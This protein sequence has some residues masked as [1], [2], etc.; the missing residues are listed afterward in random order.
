MNLQE[1]SQYLQVELL[2]PG[3]E[4]PTSILIYGVAPIDQAQ[5][6]ELTFLANIKY[7]E[8][9][10]STQASAVI[11]RSPL[12]NCPLPQIIHKDPHFAFAKIS[13]LFYQ[14]DHGP[15]SVSDKAFIDPTAKIGKDVTV[16]PFAC[17]AAD[18][19]I[20]DRA[21]LYPGV[22]IGKQ[23]SV[24]EDTVIHANTVIGERCIIGSHNLIHAGCVIG[25]DGF[26]FAVGEGTI[27]KIPQMGIVRIE[28]HVELGGCCTIDRATMG[29]THI[30][31]GTKF[32]SKVHIGHNAKIGEH[33]MFSAMTAVGGSAYV[34]NGV[35]AGGQAA[36]AGHIKIGDGVKI[37]AKA[38]V[39]SSVD[40]QQT[41][42]GFPAVPAMQWRRGLIHTKKMGE[43]EKKIKELEAR[44][45]Q[46][47][48]QTRN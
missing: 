16:Y 36:I 42:M 18:A 48:Q 33:C 31:G 32:D 43:Y 12:D 44:L 21:V 10:N 46:L 14:V 30:K 2:C 40:P 5:E 35:L 39:I 11:T 25:A 13:N 38:G 47:E 15:R 3:N 4:D 37:G 17:I 34:G 1:L 24:G 8:H 28:D 22:F 27:E 9:L 7:A 45:A 41:I 6:G 20:G 23:A 29:E 26:G 19:E